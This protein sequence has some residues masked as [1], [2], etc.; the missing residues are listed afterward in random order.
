M[1]ISQQSLDNKGHVTRENYCK[2]CLFFWSLME[3]S[4]VHILKNNKL[5]E[6]KDDRSHALTPIIHYKVSYKSITAHS[7]LQWVCAFTTSYRPFLS[8]MWGSGLWT[9]ATLS[10]LL[11]LIWLHS[12]THP[13]EQSPLAPDHQISDRKKVGWPFISDTQPRSSTGLGS[14][15]TLVFP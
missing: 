1:L 10:T 2:C 12:K 8:H 13:A 11:F 9:W 14:L 15:T 7:G 3:A 5:T 4:S 6:H